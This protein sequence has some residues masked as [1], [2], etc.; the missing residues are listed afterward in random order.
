MGFID[1][2]AP[3]GTP[4]VNAMIDFLSNIYGIVVSDHRRPVN[5]AS[6]SAMPA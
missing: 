6:R 4:D 1:D 2:L 3:L 5:V